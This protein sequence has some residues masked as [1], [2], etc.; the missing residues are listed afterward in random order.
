M[1]GEMRELKLKAEEKRALVAFLKSL[2]GKV[3]EG[4]PPAR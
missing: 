3:S 4:W 2:S 1:D